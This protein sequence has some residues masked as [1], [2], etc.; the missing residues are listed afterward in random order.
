MQE[1]D[2]SDS[3]EP[4]TAGFVASNFSNLRIREA[5]PEDAGQIAPLIYRTDPTTFNFEYGFKKKSILDYISLSFRQKNSFFS[6]QKTRVV[7]DKY[8]RIAGLVIAFDY[9][10]SARAIRQEYKTYL[11]WAGVFKTISFLRREAV[12]NRYWVLPDKDS[13]Y[14]AFY[15]IA[16]R[17]QGTGLSRYLFSE[18]LNMAKNQGY[19]KVELDVAIDNEKAKKL[20]FKM[21]FQIKQILRYEELENKYNISSTQVMLKYL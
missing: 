2:A 5:K 11:G 14:I 16:P 21:G 12:V 10:F 17:W 9:D 20:Y 19:K 8:A 3:D 15:S 1:S 6:F 13:L 7:E 18:A 4:A